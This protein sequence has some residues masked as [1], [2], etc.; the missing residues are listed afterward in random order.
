MTVI[1]NDV[2]IEY[3]NS[4][5]AS[6]SITFEYDR[7]EQVTVR[8]YNSATNKYEDV[9]DW[10]FDGA[11][12]IRFTGVVPDIFQIVRSTNISQPYG[13]S[14]YAVFQQ[15]SAIKAGDLNG[16]L[17]LLRLAIEE[18]TSELDD[19][20]DQIDDI[21]QEIDDIE[22]DVTD[23]NNGSLDGRYVNV[24]G[25]TMA[26]GLSMSNNRIQTLADPN[27]PADAV[28][29][30]TLQTYVDNELGNIDPNSASFTRFTFTAAG[31]ETAVTV[32]A[33]VTGGELVFLNGAE[34]TR[35]VDYTPTDSVTVTFTQALLAGDVFDLFC[36]NTLK[37][38]EVPLGDTTNL[39]VI[40]QTFTA[41]AGQTT[42]TLTGGVQYTP[43]KEQVFLNGN[44]L[45]RDTAYTGNV[46]TSF[47]LVQGALVGDQVEI[48]CINYT[49]T[50][51]GSDLAA[52][53]I[54]YTYPGGVEQIVQQRLEQY[55]SVKDFGAVGDG[56]TDDTQAFTDALDASRSIYVP[57]GTYL[58][59]NLGHLN[60][61]GLTVQGASRY[62]SII[63]VKPGTAGS[64]FQQTAASAGSSGNHSFDKLWFD[65]NGQDVIGINLDSTNNCVISQCFF[66]QPAI[67]AG[68]TD[69]AKREN[70]VGIGVVFAGQLYSGCY[71][72]HVT[73]CK[74]QFLSRGVQ[75]R[76]G[77]NLQQVTAC[78]AITCD[79]A[80][81][82]N[83]IGTASIDLI[84]T[85]TIVGGRAEGCN[86][87]IRDNARCGS[88]V[89]VR[90]ENQLI[91]D[92]EFNDR[93]EYTTILG[94][95]TAVTSL[96]VKDIDKCTSPNIISSEFGYYS[97][98]ESTSRLRRIRGRT[99][100]SSAGTVP[101]A[102]TGATRDSF[103]YQFNS[104]VLFD[105]TIEF[106]SATSSVLAL[107]KNGADIEL[108]NFDR[109]SQ[110]HGN[111][112]IGNT[113][114]YVRP[115]SNDTQYFGSSSAR[116]KQVHTGSLRIYSPNGTQYE[117]KVN[118]S[119]DLLFAGVKIN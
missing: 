30:R 87:G 110:T 53:N 4:G 47:E 16:N 49:T 44:L 6:Y 72:N 57:E 9:T 52:S 3:A 62:K 84:D 61:A 99:V 101:T 111:I 119:G 107:Q 28:N 12:A 78:E 69:I 92:I 115:K 2:I 108:Q 82:A 73:N 42:F 112:L 68:G 95:Y 23:I 70:Q 27:G 48:Y 71:N 76:N 25:D 58:V 75:W 102:N 45:E 100:A 96:P 90:L 93:S 5:S 113:N 24:T 20:Q 54:S 64:I 104:P 59:G 34:Q 74:F 65:F 17:E 117:L 91:C 77:A 39:P 103:C 83:T 29:L 21:N 106:P 22:D 19:H 94:G 11:T 32:P 114:S 38:I 79:I 97:S 37:V 81:D 26:G 43:G 66:S 33:Y 89:N 36:V 40:R 63:K 88:Y 35:N 118:D 51:D 14:K 80:Y 8:T 41:T 18:S 1:Q 15:G 105:S 31:G 60:S 13:T 7:A 67:G 116:W 46:G 85:P 10:V 50:F 55:V 56:V 109:D 86:I 98:E